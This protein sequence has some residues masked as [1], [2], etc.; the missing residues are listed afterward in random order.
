M[1]ALLNLNEMTSIIKNVGI[2]NKGRHFNKEIENEGL[3]GKVAQEVLRCFCCNESGKQ[4]KIFYKNLMKLT[5]SFITG[6][7]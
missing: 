2:F 5:K 6:N 3:G 4:K 1:V 7:V